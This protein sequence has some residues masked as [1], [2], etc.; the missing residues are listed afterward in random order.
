MPSTL[1][2]ISDLVRYHS[3]LQNYKTPKL[4][5]FAKSPLQ[6][7]EIHFQNDIFFRFLSG[8]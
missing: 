4:L 1:L 2:G 8:K 7:L 3:K 5:F 6:F